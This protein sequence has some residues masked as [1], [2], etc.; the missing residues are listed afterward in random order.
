[1]RRKKGDRERGYGNIH[2]LQRS[3]KKGILNPADALSALPGKR[4]RAYSLNSFTT[5]QRYRKKKNET[6]PPRN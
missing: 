6:R 1:M 5:Y 2:S 4:W 3:P